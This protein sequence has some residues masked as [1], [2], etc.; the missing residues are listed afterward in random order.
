LPAVLKV[1]KHSRDEVRRV[2]LFAVGD[3]RRDGA[4][5]VIERR[6]ATFVL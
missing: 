2:A 3:K 6:D 1:E 4:G 5:Q